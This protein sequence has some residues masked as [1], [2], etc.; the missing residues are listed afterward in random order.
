MPEAEAALFTSQKL[1]LTGNHALTRRFAA[2]FQARFGQPPVVY[3]ANYYN[4]AYLFGLLAKQVEAA[5]GTVNGD[6]LR[7]AMLATRKFDLVGGEGEFDEQGNML[8]QMQVNEIRGQQFVAI[9]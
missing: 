2:D 4:A 5:G 3:H 6:S 8:T 7:A 1:D 9:G